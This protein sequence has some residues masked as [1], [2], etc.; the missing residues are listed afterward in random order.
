LFSLAPTVG[1]FWYGALFESTQTTPKTHSSTVFH[2]GGQAILL[3]MPTRDT[4]QIKSEVKF[5]ALTLSCLITIAELIFFSFGVHEASA[6]GFYDARKPNS[7]REITDRSV[8]RLL[9]SASCAVARVE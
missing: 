8:F 6:A 5:S 3:Q 7:E 1:D 4:K 2:H 9:H